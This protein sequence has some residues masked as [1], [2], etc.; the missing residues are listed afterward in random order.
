[1]PNLWDHLRS[2]FRAAETSSPSQPVVHEVLER[3]A[4]TTAAYTR[5]KASLA[6]RRMLNWLADQYAIYLVCPSDIDAALGFLDGPSSRGMVIHFAHTNYS[7]AEV[8]HLFD[9]FK[10]RVQTL[11]YKS[12]VSDLRTYARAHWVETTERHYLKPRLDFD[13]EGRMN[14]QFG[15]ILIELEL[16]ND[17][18]HNLRF[19][20]TSYRDRNY[21]PPADFRELMGVIL[22]E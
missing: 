2:L 9:Y 6:R 13:D 16:R 10:E 1:M 5:W 8:T 4:D 12:Q 3:D 11:N 7:R 21:L 17:R 19:R 18:V 20:A 22:G 14:Q 15:N